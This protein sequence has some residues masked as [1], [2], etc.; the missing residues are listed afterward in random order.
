MT[1]CLGLMSMVSACE[2]NEAA[3]DF[4]GSGIEF[5]TL[6]TMSDTVPLDVRITGALN[7]IMTIYNVPEE[8][9]KRKI[10][11]VLAMDYRTIGSQILEELIEYVEKVNVQAFENLIAIKKYKS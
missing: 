11:K 2:E 5:A 3:R 9:R 8:M 1:V 7:Q 10:E 4:F 6:M